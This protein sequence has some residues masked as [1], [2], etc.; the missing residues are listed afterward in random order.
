MSTKPPRTAAIVC[1]LSSELEGVLRVLRDQCPASVEEKTFETLLYFETTFPDKDGRDINLILT[2]PND[3]G[4]QR[5][6]SHLHQL[7]KYFQIHFVLMTGICAGRREKVELG[8]II[9]AKSAID[10]SAG[11]A[12]NDGLLRSITMYQ[13]DATLPPMV[14]RLNEP[15]TLSELLSSVPS[16]YS[17][18][19]KQDALLDLVRKSQ[20]GIKFRDAERKLQCVCGGDFKKI[21]DT[22]KDDWIET[23]D[24]KLYLK[25]TKL[26]E[27]LQKEAVGDFPHT[28]GKKRG[29]LAPYAVSPNSVVG[30]LNDLK[31]TELSEDIAQ[32]DT[33]A[34][35]ME[36]HAVYQT[37]HDYN[38]RVS[39][40]PHIKVLVVKGVV[41]FADGDKDDSFHDYAAE[42]SGLW[43][44]TFLR[45]Y[46]FS[47]TS[48]R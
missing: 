8:D 29:Y 5:I 17:K 10:I 9:V 2:T 38:S 11:K 45:R 34:L 28:D 27:I 37:V 43:A 33:L 47:A 36:S 25:E 39:D 41:D 22:L 44:Y 4:G 30:N 40:A 24:L 32:R 18:R 15:D 3:A 46:L 42:V 26:Q 13:I 19:H 14:A 21:F 31:W 20:H 6:A 35:E 48:Y 7:L 1:A 16:Q 23:K 12:T